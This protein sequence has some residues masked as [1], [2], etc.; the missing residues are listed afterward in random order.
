MSTVGPLTRSHPQAELTAV[1]ESGVRVTG[2]TGDADRDWLLAHTLA[3]RLHAEAEDTCTGALPTYESVLVEFDPARTGLERTL[4]LLEAALDDLDLD[5]PLHPDPRHFRVPV[6]YGSGAEEDPWGPDM[7]RVAEVTGLGVH[8]IIERHSGSTYLIRCLG[9]PGGS[10]MVYGPD[11]GV[12]IPRLRS[13]RASVPQ[14]AVSLAGLQA[15]IAPTSAPGGWCVIGRTPLVQLDLGS[16]TL[17]PYRPG[18]TLRFVPV[19]EHE[20][21]AREGAAMTPEEVA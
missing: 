1:G 7:A 8:E 14:G 20:F 21:R 5:G 10:P 15:T 2:R 6:L 3:A 19:D 4:D 13:P 12:P 18:D 9:A 17:V 11:L 16:P